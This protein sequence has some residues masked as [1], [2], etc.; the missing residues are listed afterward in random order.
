ML[1]DKAERTTIACQ[2]VKKGRIRDFFGFNR[3]K[4]AVVEASI[5]ATRLGLVPADEVVSELE[6]LRVL[7]DKTSG[8]QERRAFQFIEQFVAETMSR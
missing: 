2:V 6:R 5:L 4:H 8:K 3:A 7:V 1:D